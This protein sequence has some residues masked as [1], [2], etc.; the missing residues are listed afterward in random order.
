MQSL[1][2]AE[3]PAPT[4]NLKSI[5]SLLSLTAKSIACK[6]IVEAEVVATKVNQLN[7]IEEAHYLIEQ[8]DSLLADV[9]NAE[10]IKAYHEA[11]RKVQSIDH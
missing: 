2:V 10:V 11:L 1:Q 3:I 6:R 4:S 5:K 7:K 9:N 8:G